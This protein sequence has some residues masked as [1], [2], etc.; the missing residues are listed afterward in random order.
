MDYQ[1]TESGLRYRDDRKSD[2]APVTLGDLVRV[3]YQVAIGNSDDLGESDDAWIDD[4][5]AREAPIAFRVGS[6]RVIRGVD[7]GVQG[8]TLASYRTLLVPPALA[9]GARGVPNRV[10]SEATLT[11]KLYVVDIS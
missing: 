10:P 7:E 11:F 8:M 2:G 4:S 9:F 6:G 1:S 5:W 3:H